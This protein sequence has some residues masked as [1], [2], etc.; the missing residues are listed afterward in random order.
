MA[1]QPN[2]QLN[3]GNMQVLNL[4]LFKILVGLHIIVGSR[5]WYSG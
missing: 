2:Q 4:V 5:R 1:V 3:L